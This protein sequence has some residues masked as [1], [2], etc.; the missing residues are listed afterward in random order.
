MHECSES[1]V[2]PV[3]ERLLSTCH[4]RIRWRGRGARTRA[5]CH[6]NCD[7]DSEPAAGTLI[8]NRATASQPSVCAGRR[9]YAV[10]CRR[11]STLD[12]LPDSI[13]PGRGDNK[14]CEPGS[15]CA[16]HPCQHPADLTAGDA[17]KCSTAAAL[18]HAVRCRAAQQS[19]F[20]SM[21]FLYYETLL[22]MPC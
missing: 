13:V 22:S 9:A 14:R 16:T 1:V 3:R 10:H 4:G 20:L 18:A 11:P 19:S 12:L 7:Q 6:S 8:P 21:R 15:T 2:E 17:G 5:H